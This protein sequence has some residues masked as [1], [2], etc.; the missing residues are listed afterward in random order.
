MSNIIQLHTAPKPKTKEPE[1]ITVGDAET[2][3][4]TLFNAVHKIPME[5][6][7]SFAAAIVFVEGKATSGRDA[8][9]MIAQ[10]ICKIIHHIDTGEN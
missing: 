5:A 6:V 9:H 4:A 10:R 1:V 2:Y 3:I 8:L 7:P